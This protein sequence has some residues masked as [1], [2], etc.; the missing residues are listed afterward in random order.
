[1][2]D[3]ARRAGELAEVTPFVGSVAAV[4]PA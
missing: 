4:V 2:L 3:Y 1:V